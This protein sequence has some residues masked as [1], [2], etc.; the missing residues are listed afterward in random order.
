[1]SGTAGMGEETLVAAER[2]STCSL[3]PSDQEEDACVYV[4]EEG[5]VP[6][7]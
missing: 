5:E 6:R 2:L 4:S 1:M 7:L 3:R